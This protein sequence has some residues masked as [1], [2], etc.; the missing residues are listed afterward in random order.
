[1]TTAT[2]TVEYNVGDTVQYH[3]IGSDRAEKVATVRKAKMVNGRQI[4]HVDWEDGVN[5]S[6]KRGYYADRFSLI[7][8]SDLA[9]PEPDFNAGDRVIYVGPSR[10]RNG[11]KAMVI[12]AFDRDGE[13]ILDIEW[14]RMTKGSRT[15]G[16]KAK[17][18]QLDSSALTIRESVDIAVDSVL[19][20]SI[21]LDNL[22]D[23]LVDSVL[24]AL[25]RNHNL[26]D[27]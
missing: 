24:Q 27:E 3:G 12:N 4:I 11:Q 13:T 6:G 5:P 2:A 22:K 18:F 8:E 15:H 19:S 17:N 23:T 9:E 16:L 10:R 20:S 26:R 21:S 7:E 14:D 25:N 1:M